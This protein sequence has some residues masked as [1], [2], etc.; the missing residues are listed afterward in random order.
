MKK[1]YYIYEIKED[2]TE[3]F[4]KKEFSEYSALQWIGD[5]LKRSKYKDSKFKIQTIYKK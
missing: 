1:F 3:E 5:N 4:K 2:W